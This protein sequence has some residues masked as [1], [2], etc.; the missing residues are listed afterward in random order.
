M[1]Q[2]VHI[3]VFASGRGSNFQALHRALVAAGSPGT[4]ALCVS[5]NPNPGAFDIARQHG[6]PT[7][8]LSPTMFPEAE[9][10]ESALVQLLTDHAIQ[11]IVL[12]G[13]MRRLPL[14]VVRGWEGK[15]LNVHPALLPDFGGQGMYGMNVHQAVI[16]ARRTESG[17]TVHLVDQ[18]YDTGAIIAQERVPV[19]PDDTPET[20]AARVLQAE[21]HLLPQVVMEMVERE[22]ENGNR[23]GTE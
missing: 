18:E 13:Y 6:I 4:I 15:I 23:R 14:A 19:L 9:P 16:A 8:R 2:P 21:H 3:A 10:Y 20:L 12:A 17:A 7:A 1:R 11:I 22:L 5:N